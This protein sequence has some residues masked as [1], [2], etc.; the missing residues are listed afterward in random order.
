MRLPSTVEWPVLT[1]NSLGSKTVIGVAA[2]TVVSAVEGVPQIEAN[3]NAELHYDTVPGE[4]VDIAGVRAS[5]VGSLY[6]TDTVGLK[7]RWPISWAL[8]DVRGI[9]WLQ[10]VNW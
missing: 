1:S 5:P 7:L 10:N 6:Q 8:R 2:A 9:A 4:I 3:K